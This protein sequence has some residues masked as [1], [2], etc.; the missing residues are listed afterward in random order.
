[1]AITPTLRDMDTSVLLVGT[2]YNKWGQWIPAR[3]SYAHSVGFMSSECS[4]NA[5]PE[6]GIK[7]FGSMLHQHTA[8]TAL[9]V[10]HIRHGKELPPIDINLSYEFSFCLIFGC[11]HEHEYNVRFL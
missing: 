9:R 4:E 3:L 6:Q 7:I 5:F 1:M 10:G 11:S 8:G 2:N